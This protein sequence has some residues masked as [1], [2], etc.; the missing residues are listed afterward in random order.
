MLLLSALSL[1]RR[2]YLC[3]ELA[4]VADAGAQAEAQATSARGGQAQVGSGNSRR[5]SRWRHHTHAL[6]VVACRFCV[7]SRG[8][9]PP[10]PHMCTR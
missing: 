5:C 3:R 1:W 6:A 7:F 4:I 10:P 9:P 2:R 8:V